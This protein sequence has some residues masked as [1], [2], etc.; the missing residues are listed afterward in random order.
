M[1]H[2]K[3]SICSLA[4]FASFS[5]IYSAE[6]MDESLWAKLRHEMKPLPTRKIQGEYPSQDIQWCR[7]IDEGFL[8]LE[9]AI[10]A[11]GTPLSIPKSL[12]EFHKHVGDLAFSK[13]VVLLTPIKRKEEADSYFCQR[14]LDT[15]TRQLPAEWLI[16]AEMDNSDCYCIHSKTG[17][18]KL[19]TLLPEVKE[20]GGYYRNIK[21][22]AQEVFLTN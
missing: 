20:Q 10:K 19:F 22:W 11:K 2:F 21:H 6:N 9:E 4:A 16:F 5:Y 14:I 17:M 7:N 18:V 3:A 13:S 15:R 1:K 8:Q 12:I